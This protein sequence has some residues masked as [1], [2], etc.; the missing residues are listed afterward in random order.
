MKTLFVTSRLH[1]N[2]SAF[3]EGDNMLIE[4]SAN[5]DDS[6]ANSR[7]TWSAEEGP[8]RSHRGPLEPT[9]THDSEGQTHNPGPR[10]DVNAIYY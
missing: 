6:V 3:V 2:Y 1:N 5:K 8:L 4:L 10:A 7:A 9:R